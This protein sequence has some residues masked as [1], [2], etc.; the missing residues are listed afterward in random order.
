MT[1]LARGVSQAIIAAAGRGTRFL[2]CTKVTPKELLPLYDRPVIHHL[3]DE[4]AA[5]GLSEV[6][7]V[8]RPDTV[9]PLQRYFSRDPEWDRFLADHGKQHLLEPL[10]TLLDRLRISVVPQPPGLPYGSGTPLLAVWDRLTA[11]FV[12]LYADDVILDS[13]PGHSLRVLLE[14]FKAGG[15]AACV[16]ACSVPR[17]RI[18]QVGSI[19]YRP[20]A[21]WQ[22]DHIVEKP[23]PGE[24]PSEYTPIG[25]MV[26]T[27]AVLPILE[28]KRRG[29]K[30]G[31]ELWMTEA[32]STLAALDRVLAPPVQG[33]WLTTGDPEN[34]LRAGLAI[35]RPPH[36]SPCPPCGELHSPQRSG[37]GP[38]P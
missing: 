1:L 29:L 18:P 13:V 32:V 23:R 35:S 33:R 5:A 12:Y 16:G 8:A 30:P 9:E 6:V 24:A 17:E 3:L 25:R 11:P 28:Q 7:I 26:L 34:L 36:L 2:P 27:P 31:R 38:L 20:G 4:I 21:D 37:E 10:Y 14:V 22:V 15:I 19:A